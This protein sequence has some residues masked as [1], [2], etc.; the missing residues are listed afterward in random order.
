MPEEEKTLNHSGRQVLYVVGRAEIDNSCCGVAG[1]RYVIVP[2]YVVVWKN[3]MDET[4][5]PLSEVEP[6]VDED[7]R[8]KITNI[9]QEKEIVTQIDFW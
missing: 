3:G 7:S 2:G 5:R 9:L 6:I 8:R 4:G 1:C